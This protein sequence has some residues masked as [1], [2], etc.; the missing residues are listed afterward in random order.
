MTE[1]H[2]SHLSPQGKKGRLSFG[3]LSMSEYFSVNGLMG[4]ILMRGNTSPARSLS[5]D[6]RSN[7]RRL[8]WNTV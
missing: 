8:R 3:R 7:Y 1:N 6:Q 4:A 2:T 5:E